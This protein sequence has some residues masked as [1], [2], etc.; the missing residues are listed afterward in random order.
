MEDI[1]EF[2]EYKGRHNAYYKEALT[3]AYDRYKDMN[4]HNLYKSLEETRKRN[5]GLNTNETVA[6]CVIIYKL[7]EDKGEVCL[8]D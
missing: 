4:W 5:K 1:K 7:L 6:D 2:I 3:I 8:K